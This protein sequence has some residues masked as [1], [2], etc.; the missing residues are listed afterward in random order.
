MMKPVVPMWQ[1]RVRPSYRSRFY[2]MVR[3]FKTPRELMRWVRHDGP[4]RR[5]SVSK[6]SIG[7]CSVW[8]REVG[9]RNPEIGEIGLCLPHSGIGVISHECLHA[10]FFYLRILGGDMDLSRDDN[11]GGTVAGM[12]E[13]ACEVL[14]YLVKEVVRKGY[15]CGW[16]EEAASNREKAKKS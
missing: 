15:N 14:G 13:K 8:G 10:T 3:I 12:E 5:P 4:S 2:Y 6:H 7:I 16:L 9:C 1:F 11:D